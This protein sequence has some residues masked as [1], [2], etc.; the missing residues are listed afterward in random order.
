MAMVV[1]ICGIHSSGPADILV[2]SHKATHWIRELISGGISLSQAFSYVTPVL[3]D[4]LLIFASL[5][6]LPLLVIGCLITVSVD[7][8]YFIVTGTTDHGNLPT[9]LFFLCFTAIDWMSR[10]FSPAKCARVARRWILLMMVAMLGVVTVEH[11]LAEI[12]NQCRTRIATWNWEAFNW[13][14]SHHAQ[15]IQTCIDL[16]PAGRPGILPEAL[17]PYLAESNNVAILE[18]ILENR[19]LDIHRPE[20]I[21]VDFRR[22][23]LQNLSEH[24]RRRNILQNWAYP[25][26][27]TSFP[28]D[29]GSENEL[30]RLISQ[31]LSE[32]GIDITHPEQISLAEQLECSQDGVVLI[33][34]PPE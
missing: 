8:A 33:L 16:I 5:L 18:L 1:W 23:L 15:A 11:T 21:L 9:F 13:K 3:L 7:L 26:F 2:V 24:N 12:Q 30:F 32:Q 20:W 19:K 10:K 29:T 31:R 17:A 4:L 25:R 14:A 27:G 22:L 28:Y 34:L 6:F